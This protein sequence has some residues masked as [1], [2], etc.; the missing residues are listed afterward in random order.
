MNKNQRSATIAGL[1]LVAASL[2]FAPWEIQERNPSTGRVITTSSKISPVF[3]APSTATEWRAKITTLRI[4]SLFAEWAGLAIIY[5]GA[6]V[7]LKGK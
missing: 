6:F 3:L 2:L 4:S 5:A 1:V 7:L